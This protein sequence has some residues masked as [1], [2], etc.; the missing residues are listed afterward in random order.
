[1]SKRWYESKTIRRGIV[2]ALSPL[3]LI[4]VDLLKNPDREIGE[5]EMA[6]L[7][8]SVYGL[9][10]IYEGR[11][12][13]KET[14][15]KPDLDKKLQEMVAAATSNAVQENLDRYNTLEEEIS[16]LSSV[17]DVPDT[18][19]ES[20]SNGEVSLTIDG[21]K[22]Y[23]IK[24]NYEI[25]FNKNSVI[26][27]KLADSSELLSHE[28]QSVE[29]GSSYQIETYEKAA[30]NH[31]RVGFLEGDTKYW[32][33]APHVNIFNR[34]GKEV[35]LLDI[36]ES[37]SNNIESNTP[38]QIITLPNGEKVDLYGPVLPR[39]HISWAEVT[40]NNTR[41]LQTSDQVR[42]VKDLCKILEEIRAF[43][44][45]L[46]MTISSFY[47]DPV[48]N[49]AVGGSSRSVHLTAAACDFWI[50][51]VSEQK[52][53]SYMDKRG[54]S[55]GLAIK[56]GVFCHVDLAGLPNG[57]KGYKSWRRWTY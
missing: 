24:K 26:K 36:V 10:G 1:M 45:G 19:N 52:I 33:F 55:G 12:N 49:D 38:K 13:A 32:V 9:L 42:Y 6:A 18:D 8:T 35:S 17:V 28:M 48:S 37:T 47:R 7:A 30:S 11:K 39:G 27:T 4:A 23:G 25:R 2:T 14:I 40:K 20:R 44:G 22:N 15:G 51:G 5:A 41:K 56:P 43:F 50:V 54:W 57:P 21:L 3:I 29:A 16:A 31:L 53:Y 34:D 46:P